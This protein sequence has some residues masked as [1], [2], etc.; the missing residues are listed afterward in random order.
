MKT[1][2]PE[3]EQPQTETEYTLLGYL[4]QLYGGGNAP[5]LAKL[6]LRKVE[7]Q[8]IH[9]LAQS[10]PAQPLTENDILLITYADTLIQD[11]IKPLQVLKKFAERF[12]QPHF[13]GIHILPFFPFSSDDGFAVVDYTAVRADLG[14]WRDI[15]ILGEKFDLMFD[16]VINHCSR[17]HIWFTDFITGRL[18]GRDYFIALPA[19]TDTRAVV[20]PR[21]TPLLNAVETYEGTRHVWATFSDDQIDLNFANPDVLCRFV[22]IL[23]NYVD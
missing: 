11:N 8:R 15:N 14:N 5:R 3:S 7:R 17:E 23:F 13:S 18:P 9:A 1:P 6:L 19:D 4:S 22:E 2:L 16:L 12:L 21:N 20:R 10:Q